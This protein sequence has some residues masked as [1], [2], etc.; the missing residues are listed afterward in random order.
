MKNINKTAAFA[1]SLLLCC[2]AFAP[3]VSYA[4]EP[5]G[6]YAIDD[7]SAVEDPEIKTSGSFSYSVTPDGNAC[8]EDCTLQDKELVIPDEIDG[9]KVTELGA[10]AFGESPAEVITIP[11]SVE[12]IYSENPFARCAELKEIKVDGN[13]EYY[14]LKDGVLFTK[15]MSKMV[16]YPPKKSGTTYTVPEGVASIGVAAFYN[17]TELTDI[18]LPSTAEEMGHHTFAGC[19]SLKSID[20]SNTTISFIEDLAFFDCSS[21]TDVKFYENT[22]SVGMAAFYM[23]KN[24]TEITLPQHL[25]EIGQSAFMGTGLKEITVPSS[26]EVIGYSALG[27]DE[28]ENAV[29]GFVIIGEANSEAQRYCTDTDEEYDYKNNFEFVSAEYEQARKEY[30]ALDTKVSGDYE[31]MIEDGKATLVFCSSKDYDLTLPTEIDGYELAKIY[32][33]A[34]LTCDSSEITIPETVKSIGDTAFKETLIVLNLPASCTVIEGEEP[35][36]YCQSLEEIN[37]AQG[38]T[39][40]SSENGVLYNA[41]KTELIAY[42]MAK[43]QPDFT[44]PASLK[45]IGKSA[46]CN[47]PYI[48]SANLSTVTEIDTYAFEGCSALSDVKFS[49][50]LVSVG[51]DAF[52]DCIS[53]KSVRL[54]DKLETLGECAFGYYFDEEAA[55]EIQAKQA[56][57]AQQSALES[58]MGEDEELPSTDKLVE[59]FKIYA[60]EGTLGYNYAE[61]NNIETVSNTLAVGSKN[62]DK[63]FLYGAAGLASAALLAV[64]GIFTGKSISKK[65]AQKKHDELVR[66]SAEKVKKK[67]E[68]EAKEAEK[69][70]D[71]A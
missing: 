51:A 5:T 18:K 47:N 57:K 22:L 3:A 35:F 61:A 46:F 56:E 62:M 14:I 4:E 55:A 2:G 66:S 9:K 27:Y 13:S 24:L 26:V 42:P 65:N 11:A 16:M 67:H 34:F 63:G 59:G 40:F 53:L 36:I 48:E 69:N 1:L 15:D 60:D 44:A 32:K 64:I 41:D 7:G 70:E 6:L 38:N 30:L 45:K 20:L 52:Y 68:E 39:A 29:E 31:Y 10:G 58:I 49:K 50:D 25:K 43:W 33:G 71:K 19:T 8:I 21:L 17:N 37:V 12:Y 54:Y 23:C 28:N